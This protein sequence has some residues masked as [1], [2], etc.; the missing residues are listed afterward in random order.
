MLDIDFAR[1]PGRLSAPLRNSSA[2]PRI[3]VSGVRS[4]CEASATKRRRRSSERRH[5]DQHGDPDQRL[6]AE[7]APQRRVNLGEGDRDDQRA[8]ARDGRRTD[9]IVAVL[10]SRGRGRVGDGSP[11]RSPRRSGESGRDRGGIHALRRRSDRSGSNDLP[12]GINELRIGTAGDRETGRAA[13]EVAAMLEHADRGHLSSRQLLVHALD[14]R[15]RQVVIRRE[16]GGHQ[17]E[18]DERNRNERQPR[19]EGHPHS[20]GNRSA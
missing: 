18:R 1:S 5:R 15:P 8:A 9:P 10:A 13:P 6:E 11:R 7:Q 20:L 3:E 16:L 2:Y 14:Q 19:P 17:S 4:S 12:G